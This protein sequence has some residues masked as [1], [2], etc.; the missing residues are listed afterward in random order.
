MSPVCPPWTAP[1]L[2]Q[3]A[4][5]TPAPRPSSRAA[6]SIWYA[7]AA[8][9]HTNPLGNA[10]VTNPCS[11]ATTTKRLTDVDRDIGDGGAAMA[12][13]DKGEEAVPAA[14]L[15]KLHLGAARVGMND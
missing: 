15:G 11:E 5:Q 10:M 6:P 8:A 13:E 3:N 2:A 1:F 9:P 4:S 14:L 12:V 7:A